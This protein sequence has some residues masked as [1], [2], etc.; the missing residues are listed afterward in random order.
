MRV[1]V[2]GSSGMLGSEVVRVA[3]ISGIDLLAVSRSGEGGFDALHE[4][5]ESWAIRNRISS[6]DFL[7][8]AIGWIPQKASGNML[9]DRS[10][11]TLLN[12]ELIASISDAQ[13]KLGFRWLQIGTDCVYSGRRGFYTEIDPFDAID[14][15]GESKIS[16]ESFCSGA[17]LVRSS[18]V[19]PDRKS[20]AGLYAWFKRASQLGP[21]P[22]F[23]NHFWNGVS[24]TA[25]ARLALGL[26]HV[27]VGPLRQHWTPADRVSKYELL[28]MFAAEL[29]LRDDLIVETQGPENV[30]RTLETSNPELNE[31]LWTIAGYDGVPT[32][33]ELVAEMVDEEQGLVQ[34]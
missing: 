32:I 19:G 31:R 11:A 10:D 13:S 6:D 17:I 8:N 27:D 9:R 12:T 1:V 3:Q 5:F 22:G 7:V 15:Y 18:I 16:G 33:R 14:I 26:A 29:D 24:T 21:V 2:L 4:S 28:K 20:Q 34:P 23:S 30:D 25:F